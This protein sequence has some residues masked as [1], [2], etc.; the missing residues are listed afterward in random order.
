MQKKKK[1]EFL[2]RILGAKE[3]IPYVYSW[4]RFMWIDEKSHSLFWKYHELH[5][6]MFNESKF[7]IEIKK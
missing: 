3:I 4:N 1:K 5:K 7:E 6:K 2:F